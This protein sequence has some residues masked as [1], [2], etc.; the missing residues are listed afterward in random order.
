[1]M[2]VKTRNDV[3]QY[4]P[5]LNIVTGECPIAFWLKFRAWR[6]AGSSI[7]SRR[8]IV[9]NFAVNCCS[10]PAFCQANCRQ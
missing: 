7:P 3:N 1:M 4:R 2:P 6:S 5:T 8:N 9:E 10:R